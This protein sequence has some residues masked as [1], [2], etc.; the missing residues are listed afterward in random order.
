M[1]SYEDALRLIAGACRT[2]EAETSPLEASLGRSPVGD[3]SSRMNV[4]SFDNSAMDGFA[5]LAADT[6]SA[7]ATTPVV[8][9]VAGII[10]AGQGPVDGISGP[11][12][13]IMTGAPLPAGY[14]TVIPVERV[15]AE[16]NTEGAAVSIRCL[17]PF[18]P[19]RHIRRAG[20]DFQTGQTILKQGRRIE[21]HHIMGLAATGTDTVETRR[22]PR[23]AL[24]TTGNELATSGIP[25]GGGLIRDANGPYLRTFF[26]T[27]QTE[28]VQTDF[29]ADDPAVLKAAIE[30]SRDKADIVL[31]T[32]GVS[33]GRFDLIPDAIEAL[34]GKIIFH[35]VAM[36]PGKPLLFARLD[37]GT[38]FF[39]LPGNP[40]AVAVGL[41]F[42]V[43]QALSHLQG[44]V[45]ERFLTSICAETIDTKM[46]L[47][48]FGKARAE[49]DANGC[50]QTRLLPGQ[51]SFKIHSLM[52]ANCWAIVPEGTATA[53]AGGR[54]EIAPLYPSGLVL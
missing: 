28:L 24:I 13:E 42:F 3:V 48:F 11:A 36:R 39:G 22:K 9:P 4:P 1:I 12:V 35:K 34:G 43:L 45:K 40:V 32:G 19:G 41:R 51:E 38:P 14:D 18:A 52:Q 6:A 16:R 17:E 49:I 29:A 25:A 54:I 10:A 23:V 2:L 8:I 53:E 30:A 33:A 26:A 20:Q 44:Y 5:L 21:P 37:D 47:T 15:E 7:G 50:L 31:T 27:T 46:D